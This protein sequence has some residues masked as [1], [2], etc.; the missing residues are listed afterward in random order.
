MKPNY[1]IPFPEFW[2]EGETTSTEE[3]LVFTSQLSDD[4]VRKWT[5]SPSYGNA[6]TVQGS[7]EGRPC[8]RETT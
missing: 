1:V 6:E 8:N 5:S 7:E 3:G 2:D 4:E